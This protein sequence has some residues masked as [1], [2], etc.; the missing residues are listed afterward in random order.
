MYQ[1]LAKNKKKSGRDNSYL[2]T[3]C[4]K[5]MIVPTKNDER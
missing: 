4:G 1:I 5:Y 3:I 2:I